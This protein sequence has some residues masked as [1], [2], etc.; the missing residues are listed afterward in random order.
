LIEAEL[1]SKE[2]IES[3]GYKFEMTVTGDK[4]EVFAVPVEYGKTGTMS[5]FIDQT[6]VLRGADRAGT[7]ATSSDPPIH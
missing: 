7:S 3:S 2:V 6:L 1:V 4:F 5:Y